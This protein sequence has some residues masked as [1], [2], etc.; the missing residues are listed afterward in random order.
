M[1]APACGLLAAAICNNP[2]FA[3]QCCH[4]NC[5]YLQIRP[6]PLTGLSSALRHAV[7]A[8]HSHKLDKQ[9]NLRT[10]SADRL[11]TGGESEEQQ[12]QQPQQWGNIQ[13]SAPPAVI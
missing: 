9:A 12:K 13:H 6:A 1:N 8:V 2:A 4:V 11:A 3:L 5:A 7:N 10:D